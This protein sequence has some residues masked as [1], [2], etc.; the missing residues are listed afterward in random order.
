MASHHLTRRVSL[1]SL[2]MELDPLPDLVSPYN[3]ELRRLPDIQRLFRIPQL[4]EKPQNPIIRSLSRRQGRFPAL[5]TEL[6]L[7][8]ERILIADD[9]LELEGVEIWEE[10]AKRQSPPGVSTS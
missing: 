10:A 8:S 2:F 3:R 4:E 5:P 1:T 6:V 7:L 9:T